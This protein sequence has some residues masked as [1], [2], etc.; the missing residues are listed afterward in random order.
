MGLF[1]KGRTRVKATFHRT[2]SVI[3]SYSREGKNLSY[4]R[5]NMVFPSPIV[6]EESVYHVLSYVSAS[7][8]LQYICMYILY[9]QMAFSPSAAMSGS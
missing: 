3:C 8:I 4:S 5:I 2:D 7:Y 9:R 6:D 1:R